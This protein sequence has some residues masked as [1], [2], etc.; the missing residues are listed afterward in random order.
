M[1]RLKQQQ[2]QAL[3]LP[4]AP[5]PLFTDGRA[6]GAI[7]SIRTVRSFAAE[8]LEAEKYDVKVEHAYILAKKMGRISIRRVLNTRIN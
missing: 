2:Q 6:E 4:V 1:H 5:L 8:I 7:S 3:V